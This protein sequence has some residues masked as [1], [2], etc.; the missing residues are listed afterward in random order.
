M[1]AVGI[2]DITAK[3]RDFNASFVVMAKK[4]LVN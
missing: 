4:M 3:R 2:S 1:A